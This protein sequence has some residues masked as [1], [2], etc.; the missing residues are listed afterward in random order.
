MHGI[1]GDE[2]TLLNG[3]GS[4]SKLERLLMHRSYIEEPIALHVA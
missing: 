4:V 2:P 3:I 1:C